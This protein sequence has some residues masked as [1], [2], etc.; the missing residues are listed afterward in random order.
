MGIKILS[1]TGPTESMMFTN[2]IKF[3]PSAD[4]SSDDVHYPYEVALNQICN[5]IALNF[6]E[7][8]IIIEEASARI[9][10]GYVDNKQGWKAQKFKVNRSEH[11]FSSIYELRCMGVDAT[12]FL[13]KW[14]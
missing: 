3:K 9:A 11:A 8:F 1:H 6:C 7:N 14:G 4:D 2:I 5:W 12:A 10:G 13:L